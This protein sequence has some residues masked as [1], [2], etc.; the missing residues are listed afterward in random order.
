MSN[1]KTIANHFIETVCHDYLK[2]G[3]ASEPE[4]LVSQNCPLRPSL[5]VDRL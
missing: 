1:P 3:C 5:V 4:V 2:D